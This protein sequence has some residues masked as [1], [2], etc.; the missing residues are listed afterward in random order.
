MTVHAIEVIVMLIFCLLQVMS[1]QRT[2][3]LFAF[4]VLLGAGPVIAEFIFWRRDHETA[5]IKHLIAIGFAVYYS[6]TLFTCNNNLVFAFVIPIPFKIV[7]R[8]YALLSSAYFFG[9]ET[10]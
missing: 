5:M 9:V 8:Y 6:Y 4:D 3:I 1:K 10:I 2:V 7:R